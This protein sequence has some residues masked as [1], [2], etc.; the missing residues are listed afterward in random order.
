M[1]VFI[2]MLAV[3]FTVIFLTWGGVV[4]Y[5]SI[6]FDIGCKDRIKR[7]ADANTIELAKREMESVIRYIENNG[8][9]EGYTSI[10]Y[11]TP[12]EDI[13]FWHDNLKA[14]LEE[15]KKVDPGA[16]Q[17]EKSN[18]LIKLRETLVDHGESVT[19]TLPPGISRFP[20]NTAYAI[21]GW[22]TFILGCIFWIWFF[23]ILNRY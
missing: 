5:K 18:I 15:L 8:L 10:L 21:W 17:L 4:I 1:K 11:R 3:V 6:V 14:S 22:V 2:G 20:N 7:A 16:S 13:G 9:T 23:I 12:K 19:V